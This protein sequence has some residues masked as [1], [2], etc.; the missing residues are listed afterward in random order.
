M[1]DNTNSNTNEFSPLGNKKGIIIIGGG[2]AGFFTAINAK[3]NN[4]D[5][6]ITIKKADLDDIIAFFENHSL[7]KH[8][9][10][11]KKS[12]MSTVQVF[13]ENGSIL[14]LDLIWKFKVKS[15]EFQAYQQRYLE[16][17]KNQKD[18]LTFHSYIEKEMK[19]INKISF[20]NKSYFLES[21]WELGK[22]KLFFDFAKV[23]NRELLDN[24]YYH[25][26]PTFFT[27]IEEKTLKRSYIL[28]GKIIYFC[29]IKDI[30][31]TTNH[32]VK[33]VEYFIKKQLKRTKNF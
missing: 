4:A 16:F 8:I 2:A 31:K 17:L 11:S 33:A 15:K 9:L 13:L 20:E 6:D 30:E 24:K 1:K 26:Y 21:L 10:V 32:D 28:K 18:Y 7:T 3:E 14:S 5:L 22:I 23:L 25:L 29:E 27:S 12:F 19:N